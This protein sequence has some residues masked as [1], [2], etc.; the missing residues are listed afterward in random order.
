MTQYFNAVSAIHHAA[1]TAP[2]VVGWKT[3]GW[4]VYDPRLGAPAEVVPEIMVAA[5]G[6]LPIALSNTG[7][8]VLRSAL[9]SVT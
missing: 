9:A 8:E 1:Q 2:A 7:A 3:G 4:V 6:V 5:R